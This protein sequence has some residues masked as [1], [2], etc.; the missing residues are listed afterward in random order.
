[1]VDRVGK[2]LELITEDDDIDDSLQELEP[3]QKNNNSSLR[4]STHTL[5]NVSKPQNLSGVK[6]V[7]N[8]LRAMWMKNYL[9]TL[10][11]WVMYLIHILL[12]VCFLIIVMIVTKTIVVRD[13]LP[14][15]DL[16]LQ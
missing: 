15:L 6:L 10:R 14:A 8:R 5:V 13:G 12:P 11:S 4:S 9:R 1:C 16:S 2:D 3:E 7:R